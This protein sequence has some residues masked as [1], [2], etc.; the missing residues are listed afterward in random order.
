M[1]TLTRVLATTLCLTLASQNA[2][3]QFSRAVVRPTPV[4]PSV[5]IGA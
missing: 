5:P 2:L 3:A 4:A 1:K